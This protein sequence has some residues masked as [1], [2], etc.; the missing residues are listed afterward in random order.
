MLTYPVVIREPLFPESGYSVSNWRDECFGLEME[1]AAVF[2]A[3]NYFSVQDVQSAAVLVC[4]RS[5]GMLN[6]EEDEDADRTAER[7]PWEHYQNYEKAIDAAL[8]VLLEAE[9]AT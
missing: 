6:R 7:L 4:N 9:D 3:A 8:R 2:A 1:C 5:W